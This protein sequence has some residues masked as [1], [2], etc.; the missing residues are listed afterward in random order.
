MHLLRGE[1]PHLEFIRMPGYEITYSKRGVTAAGLLAQLPQLLAR[2]AREHRRL[3][4]IIRD[5]RIDGVVSDNRFGLWTGDVPTVYVTH[6]LR[7]KLPAAF[8]RFEPPLTR[9]HR[10]I[11]ERFDLCWVPDFPGEPNLAGE[12]SH[13]PSPPGNVRYI[14]VLSRFEPLPDRETRYDLLALLSGP[15]PQRTIFERKVIEQLNGSGMRALV[16]RGVPGGSTSPTAS[17]GV[18]TVDHLPG[19]E[20]NRALMQA[21]LVLARAGYSTAMDLAKLGKK[22]ILVPTP[23][24]TE[25]EYLA[26]EYQHRGW[27]F[28]VLQDA[29]DL[30][31][32]LEEAEHRP[33]I[34]MSDDGGLLGAAVGEFLDL[35]DRSARFCARPA[36]FS[37][38]TIKRKAKRYKERVK[39]PGDAK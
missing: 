24:Q 25:Q 36:D 28:T 16:V 19:G 18:M 30:R 38:F 20:L 29:F 13:P 26:Y 2:I 5:Y 10:W 9:L 1:F 11:I 39:T 6:Q 4:R 21:H 32:A 3:K 8:G 15:E 22:A 23:G 31:G 33:G 12:L 17:G 37:P 27:F 34:S 14:G 35:V 7:I